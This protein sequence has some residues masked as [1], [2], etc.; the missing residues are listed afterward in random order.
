M[1]KLMILFISIAILHIKFYCI[2][3]LYIPSKPS[4]CNINDCS[5]IQL[6]VYY[7]VFNS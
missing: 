3:F 7:S 2:A 6:N 5:I 4:A 1:D